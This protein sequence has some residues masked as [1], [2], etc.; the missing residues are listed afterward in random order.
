MIVV[1]AIVPH[2]QGEIVAETAKKAGATGATIQQGRGTAQNQVLQMLGLGDTEKDIISILLPLEHYESIKTAIKEKASHSK[3]YY[4]IFFTRYVHYFV[5]NQTLAFK[6]KYK[7][8]QTSMNN[9][10]TH[11]LITIIVNAGYAEDAMAA[12]RKAG[13]SGGTILNGKGTGKT[14]DVSFFGITIVPEKEILLILV[15]KGQASA[16]LEAIKNLDCLSAP[17]SGIAYCSE[18]SDF[19]QLGKNSKQ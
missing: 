14:T 3:P 17:G 10:T 8:E 18:V 7:E 16:I 15:E 13:A 5:K 12:A 2:N 11:E 9:Q 19:I 4:G 6:A 1:T